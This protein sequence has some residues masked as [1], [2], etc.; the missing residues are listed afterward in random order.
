MADYLL[1]PNMNLPV[2]VVG[3]ALGPIWAQLLDQ[4]LAI[5]DSHTH[6]AGSGVLITPSAININDDLSF[7]QTNNLV[8]VRTVRFTS[9]SAAIPAIGS[10]LGCVYVAAADL[11]YNDGDGNQIRITQA[12]SV[13]GSTGTITGLPSGTASAAYVSGSG[14]FQFLQATSTGANID[15]ASIA[16]RYPGSYPTPSGNYVQL[17]APSS[18]ASGYALTLPALP[19]ASNTFLGINTDGTISSAIVPDNSSIELNGSTQIAIKDLGVQQSAIAIRST[20]TTVGIGGLAK[21]AS[22]NYTFTTTLADVTNSA[23]T[24]QTNGNPVWIGVI[25]GTYALRTT[26]TTASAL[27]SIAI[28]DSS[29][30]NQAFWSLLSSA[31]PDSSGDDE[32]MII[33]ASFYTILPLAAGT[34]SFK[35]RGF[36][37]TAPVVNS[38]TG[39]LVAYEMK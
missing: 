6:V 38:V 1:S 32:G 34:Y 5:V 16:I 26:S 24:I 21:S 18:L 12:G 10:D 29:N 33:P 4:C 25:A 27:G 8:S 28:T 7:N 13:A 19:A 35:L 31:A 2:P 30:V 14:T 11:Y 3:Q 17:Q 15:V 39:F 9:Q 20:G 22:I 36:K 23:I 37:N